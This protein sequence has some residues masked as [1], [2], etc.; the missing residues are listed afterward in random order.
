MKYTVLATMN[1]QHLASKI[2]DSVERYTM[3]PPLEM[4]RREPS[5]QR[6]A[7]YD[8]IERRDFPDGEKYHRIMDVNAI[9]MDCNVLIVGGTANEEE[10]MELYELS[11]QVLK[12]GAKTLTIVLPFYGYSTME[13]A[14]NSGEVVKAKTRAR[15]LSSLPKCSRGIKVILVEPHTATLIHY[16]DDPLTVH[17]LPALQFFH[18]M[19][20]DTCGIDKNMLLGTTDLG[21]AKDVR[22]MATNLHIPYAFVLKERMFGD[23]TSEALLGDVRDQKIV[24]Y[25]DMIRT[26]GSLFGAA[27]LYTEK[28]AAEIIAVT[29]HGMFCGDFLQKL[30]DSNITRVISANTLRP[31]EHPK[32]AYYD[33]SGHITKTFL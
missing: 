31:I 26:G 24:I 8:F 33:I 15:L 23:T 18:P 4:M 11:Y 32:V 9:I 6:D 22:H 25:D 28:G 14:V 3:I 2:H 12:E 13:R 19:L 21:R 20:K 16:F 1:Y 30:S 5:Y 10:F 7:F 29:T 17:A 27:D